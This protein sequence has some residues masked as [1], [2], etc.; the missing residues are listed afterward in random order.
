MKVVD[1]PQAW[2][3]V[4]GRAVLLITHSALRLLSAAELTAIVAHEVG[5]EYVD[6]DFRAAQATGNS[7]EHKRLELACDALAVAMLKDAG[8]AWEPLAPA[9]EALAAY[10][11]ERF[12]TPLNQGNYPSTKERRKLIAR[13]ASIL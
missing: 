3:G 12:G 9:L 10:N 5:H 6:S 2:I 7:S 11:L 8:L 13:V 4:H 1:P